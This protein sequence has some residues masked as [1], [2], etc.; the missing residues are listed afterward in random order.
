MRHDAAPLRQRELALVPGDDLV[1]PGGRVML[2]LFGPGHV[3]FNRAGPQ[4][5][6]LVLVPQMPALLQPAILRIERELPLAVEQLVHVRTQHGARQ[7]VDETFYRTRLFLVAD[8]TEIDVLLFHT[9]YAL[10]QERRSRARFNG[11]I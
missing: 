3:R 7:R 2:L 10:S 11:M 9:F 4:S 1:L 8:K 5:R 6:L